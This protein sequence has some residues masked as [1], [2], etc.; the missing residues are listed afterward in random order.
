MFH[1]ISLV[2]SCHVPSHS[3]IKMSDLR[4]LRMLLRSI[5]LKYRHTKVGI[6]PQKSKI[7]TKLLLISTQEWNAYN[8][9][10]LHLKG[11]WPLFKEGYLI[12]QMRCWGDALLIC[13]SLMIL[14]PPSAGQW[15]LFCLYWK[16]DF[17]N[18]LDLVTSSW[19]WPWYHRD[20]DIT[21]TPRH[22]ERLKFDWQQVLGK[23]VVDFFLCFF[24]L[25]FFIFSQHLM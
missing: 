19:P 17:P 5:F 25:F 15:P 18:S 2:L 8:L 14:R 4:Y 23:V 13:G 3:V 6:S 10:F 16:G 20:F 21:I 12:V 7:F 22:R 9:N 11:K 1:Y 24:S